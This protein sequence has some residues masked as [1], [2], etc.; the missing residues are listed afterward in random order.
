MSSTTIVISRD[1]A[2]DDARRAFEEKLIAALQAREAG[3]CV[4]MPSLNDLPDDD[5]AI[6][7]LAD[8]AI[9]AS[10]VER[11]RASADGYL[12]VADGDSRSPGTAWSSAAA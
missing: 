7:A 1:G 11:I 10:A 3:A 5:A 9:A 4:V 2:G 8:E 12:F 6:A